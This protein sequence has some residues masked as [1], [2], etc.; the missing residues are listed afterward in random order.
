MM[1]YG[2]SFNGLEVFQP[3]YPFRLKDCERP[4][5]SPYAQRFFADLETLRAKPLF[6]TRR[7]I[8]AFEALGRNEFA[9]MQHWPD[10]S[11]P[12]HFSASTLHLQNYVSLV[13]LYSGPPVTERVFYRQRSLNRDLRKLNRFLLR[14]MAAQ[15]A[16][17]T[18]S[19]DGSAE[20][21]QGLRVVSI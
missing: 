4:F 8:R 17:P 18:M 2:P 6:A 3:A 7:E 10:R 9:L 16:D 20:L 1:N 12:D 21:E 14:K 5:R 13:G 19:N 15:W 11:F